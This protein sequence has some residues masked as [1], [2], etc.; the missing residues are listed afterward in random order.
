M[1][2]TLAALIPG[3]GRTAFLA[4]EPREKKRRR[5]RVYRVT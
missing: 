5:P 2:R 3:D 4:P 1:R